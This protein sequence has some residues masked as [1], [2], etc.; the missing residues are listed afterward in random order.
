MSLQL[1]SAL[2]SQP[3]FMSWYQ[4][5]EEEAVSWGIKKQ[6]KRSEMDCIFASVNVFFI[7]SSFCGRKLCL[8]LVHHVRDI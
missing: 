2:V 5:G 8:L 3:L 6:L 1:Q 4:K 7:F